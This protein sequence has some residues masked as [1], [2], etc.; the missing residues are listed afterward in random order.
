LTRRFYTLPDTC[1]RPNCLA[2]LRNAPGE[3][4]SADRASFKTF[5]LAFA[6][7]TIGSLLPRNGDA[8]T[9]I[10]VPGNQAT[11]Q[12]GIDA[13]NAGDT[14]LV[15]PGAYA[16]NI[17]FR[18]K[19]ITVTSSAG[20]ATTIIDGSAKGPVVTFNSGEATSSKLSGFTI[21]NGFQNGLSGGGI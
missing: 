9:T 5:L 3:P 1:H 14:V 4:M 6:V 10:N 7:F 17:N 2:R 12:A 21:Q 13:A 11:I 15:G 20:P 8:Q 16:E 19:A 18:G